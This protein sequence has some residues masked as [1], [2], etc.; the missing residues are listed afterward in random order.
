MKAYATCNQEHAC[1]IY[2]FRRRV[3]VLREIGLC[4]CIYNYV[5]LSFGLS[6][7]LFFLLYEPWLINFFL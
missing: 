5:D 3:C 2:S 1:L 4:V 6:S 7:K